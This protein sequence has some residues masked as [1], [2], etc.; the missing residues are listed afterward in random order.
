LY[1]I[2]QFVV[3]SFFYLA[4]INGA[5]ERKFIKFNLFFIPSILIL[6]FIVNPT[7]IHQFS[8]LEILL[9]SMSLITYS[10]FHFYNMLSSKKRFYYVN[11]GILI[12]LFG[13]TVAFLPRN[14]HT[15]YGRNLSDILHMLN[16][17][18]Y[19]VYQFFIFIEWQ[20]SNSK[21]NNENDI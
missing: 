5:Y 19:L 7:D 1:F 13:S 21:Y 14:L 17:L 6:N 4:L 16:I 3:L 12:Y 18:L 10:T 15:I 2:G 11:V 9:T 20:N 8:L